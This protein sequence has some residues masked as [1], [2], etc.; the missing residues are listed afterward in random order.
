LLIALQGK[1]LA[2]LG[3]RAEGAGGVRGRRLPAALNRRLPGWR[4][5]WQLWQIAAA[6]LGGQRCVPESRNGAG[7]QGG[8]A[9]ARNQGGQGAVQGAAPGAVRVRGREGRGEGDVAAQG[10]LKQWLPVA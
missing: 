6:A 2:I 7:V 9:V 1:V 8:A 3:T 4:R 10:V 5:S